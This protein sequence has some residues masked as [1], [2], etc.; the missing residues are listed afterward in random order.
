MPGFH[1]L[2]ITYAHELQHI[3]QEDR[4]P[5]LM[6]VNSVLRANLWRVKQAPTEIDLP[7]E[8]EANIVSKRVVEA[9]CSPEAVKR[10]AEEQ[11]KRMKDENAVE[12]LVRWE[13]FLS[14]P[15]SLSYDFADRTLELVQEYKGRMDF[16][17][18]T[19]SPL[20]WHGRV[21]TTDAAGTY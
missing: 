13:F 12:Q 20:W 18:D 3:V 4:F 7:A 11:V 16:G 10:F 8:V 9:V 15:S 14:T 2:R 5:K 19:D 6:K 1:G 21:P 17:M